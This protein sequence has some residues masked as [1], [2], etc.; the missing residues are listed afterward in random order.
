MAGPCCCESNVK[1]SYVLGI[2]LIVICILNCFNENEEGEHLY[3]IIGGI[4]RALIHGLLVYG[5][6]ARNRTAILVWIVLA[7]IDCII[8]CVIIV[9][10]VIAVAYGGAVHWMFGMV[11]IAI[12]GGN[13]LFDIWTIIVAKNARREINEESGEGQVQEMK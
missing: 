11:V 9:I 12:Y 4:V 10:F 13:I 6:H 5:A 7:I 3:N 1:A 8:L 2:I